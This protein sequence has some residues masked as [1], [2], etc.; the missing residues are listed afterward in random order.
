[1]QNLTPPETAPRQNP[2]AKSGDM[3]KTHKS[4]PATPP[5][6]REAASCSDKNSP[7]KL[8]SEADG[9]PGPLVGVEKEGTA[10]EATPALRVRGER[11]EARAA[12]SNREE[13]RSA[14][15]RALLAIP[16]KL[17]SMTTQ[18]KAKKLAT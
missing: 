9:T 15:S 16:D 4:L 18:R 2:W 10:D 17:V 6:S 14:R 11:N 13:M 8:P 3:T 7:E 5:D 1:V 12:S